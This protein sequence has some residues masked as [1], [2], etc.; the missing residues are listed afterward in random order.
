MTLCAA[1]EDMARHLRRLLQPPASAAG[2][3][4]LGAKLVARTVLETKN[5]GDAARELADGRGA[6]V[7]IRWVR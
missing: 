1:L 6:V 5:L 3:R 4:R 7:L 2:R